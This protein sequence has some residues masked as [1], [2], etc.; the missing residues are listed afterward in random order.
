M[1]D[2]GKCREYKEENKNH[3]LN[4][5]TDNFVIYTLC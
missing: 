5:L 2:S 3:P 4:P 1:D